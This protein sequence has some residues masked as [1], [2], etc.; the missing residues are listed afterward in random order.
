MGSW[1]DLTK[2][3]DFALGHGLRLGG[4]LLLAF[5]LN[6]ILRVLTRR[7]IRVAPPSDKSRNA[8][9]QEQHTRTLAGILY[10]GGNAVI[11]IVSVL[12]ALP[13]LGF[14]VTPLAAAAGLASLAL[15]FGAQNLVR[16][17]INGFFIVFEEQFV[18]GDT[19]RIGTTLGRVEHV[20]LRRTVLRDPSGAVVTIPNS[21]IGVV[22]NLTRDWGQLFID[23]TIPADGTLDS[24]LEA[25]S[26]LALEFR[27]EADWS[28]VLVDGPRVLGVESLTPTGAVLRL[29][30]RTAPNRQDDV[31]RELRRR[32]QIRFAQQKLHLGEV[33]RVELVEIGLRGKLEPAKAANPPASS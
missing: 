2:W 23:V 28:P 30:I 4:I 24:A 11:V 12:M 14:S 9:T 27:A 31:A 18:V 5:I 32:I 20:T 16:D 10:S 19:V 6:R 22:A 13:E 33:Q 8:Q 7:L 3:T 1:M 15:G 17:C 21:E 25:L 26:A 29:Q